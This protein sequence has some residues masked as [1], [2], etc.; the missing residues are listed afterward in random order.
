MD[1]RQISKLDAARWIRHITG[2]EISP[3]D[4]RWAEYNN[5]TKIL[6]YLMNTD[7]LYELNCSSCMSRSKKLGQDNPWSEWSHLLN[8]NRKSGDAM[9]RV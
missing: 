8:P 1:N 5:E 2:Y 3:M 6:R 4:I 7:V 9:R